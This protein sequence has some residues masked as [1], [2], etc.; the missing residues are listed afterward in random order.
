MNLNLRIEPDLLRE[1]K[2]IANANDQPLSR[3][4]RAAIRE[5]NARESGRKRPRRAKA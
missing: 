2:A 1:T 3:Y 4:V 5:K